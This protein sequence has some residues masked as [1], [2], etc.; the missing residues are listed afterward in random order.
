MSDQVSS[1]RER[2]AIAGSPVTVVDDAREREWDAF[3]ESFPA[4]TGY[5]RWCWRGVF[6]RA[7]GHETVYL[8]ARRADAIVGVLPLVCFRS[9]LFGR[10]LVSLPFVNY[11]GVIAADDQAGR[12]LVDAARREAARRG[13]RSI[14][15]RHTRRQFPDLSVKEHKVA[16]RLPLPT[17]ED[18]AWKA[19]DNKVRNQV[20]KAEKSGLRA[21]VGGRE[22]LAEFYAVFARNMRDLGTPVYSRRLFQEVLQNVPD[23]HASVVRLGGTPVAA[24][25]MVGYREAIENPWASSLREHRALCPNMLLYWTMIREAIARGYRVFDFGRSTP[26]EGTYQFKKQWGALESPFYWEYALQPGTALPDHSRKNAR[27]QAAIGVWQRLPITV[28]NRLGPVI[29]RNIP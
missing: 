23:V 25:I 17:G 21:I 2:G 13:A 29:V 22:L 9:W 15:L 10:F 8:A 18:A 7:F 12:A 26:N 16:M 27:F 20:R 14:E 3:I 19:F 6:E 1:D 5:H 24:G 4:S 28:T 11:G